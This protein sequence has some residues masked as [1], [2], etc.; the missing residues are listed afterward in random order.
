MSR[1]YFLLEPRDSPSSDGLYR[2]GEATFADI[3]FGH[4]SYKDF[5]LEET[6]DLSMW[7][8]QHRGSLNMKDMDYESV[9]LN[10]LEKEDF[11]AARRLKGSD[12]GWSSDSFYN[13]VK[14]FD[15]EIWKVDSNS[16]AVDIIKKYNLN[17]TKDEL[18]SEIHETL[19]ADFEE[20]FDMETVHEIYNESVREYDDDFFKPLY[21]VY[22]REFIAD[23]SYK[24]GDIC[25]LISPVETRPSYGLSIIGYRESIKS[26]VVVSD[27]EGQPSLSPHI[28]TKLKSLKTTY[29]RVNQILN[30]EF[31]VS[32][33]ILV[34]SVCLKIMGRNPKL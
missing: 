25:L 9:V 11:N 32:G 24:V 22:C 1:P 13:N 2:S 26:K 4:V 8:E 10:Y 29:D 23:S 3:R 12:F 30:K 16:A 6:E 19:V 5:I 20:G 14:K 7:I 34:P 21:K 18:K 17:Y 31:G 15:E 33:A 28:V 27:S